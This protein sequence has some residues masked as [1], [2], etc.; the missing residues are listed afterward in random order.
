MRDCSGW[1]SGYA[2]KEPESES[3]PAPEPIAK[4]DV[5]KAPGRNYID[6]K[7]VLQTL[8]PE[9]QRLVK[10]L[11]QGP[12]HIDALSE[13]MEQPAGNVL[14]LLTMLEVRGLIRHLPG[15]KFSLAEA[16]N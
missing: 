1:N 16:E 10:L 11:E 13:Q 4:K 5:D 2:P 7:N 12:I 8:Q 15:R 9:E 14:A 6:T 3:E